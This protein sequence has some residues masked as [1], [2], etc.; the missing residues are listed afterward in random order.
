[1]AHA[2]AAQKSGMCFGFGGMVHGTTVLHFRCQMQLSQ[3]GY[4]AQTVCGNSRTT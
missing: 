3:V 1:M 4:V 2:H